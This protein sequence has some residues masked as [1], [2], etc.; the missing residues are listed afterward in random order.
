MLFRFALSRV[1]RTLTGLGALMRHGRRYYFFL[2]FGFFTSFFAPWRDAAI[3]DH[4]PFAAVTDYSRFRSWG[5]L[6]QPV[7]PSVLP[8]PVLPVSAPRSCT[9]ASCR[10]TT[11]ARA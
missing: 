8:S 9:A 1:A 10:R 7:T 4:L 3:N 5:C 2:L 11:D 6:M